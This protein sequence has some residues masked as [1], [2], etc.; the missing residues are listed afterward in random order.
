MK[1]KGV[2]TALF[3]VMCTAGAVAQQNQPVTVKSTLK[4]GVDVTRFKTYNWF[5]GQGSFD[6][7]LNK[8]IIAAID[9]ELATL[10]LTKTT[11][12]PDVL[13]RCSQRAPISRPGK[14]RPAAASGRSTR[15]ARW[16]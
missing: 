14:P 5:A 10:G 8:M 11:T 13:A 16:S 2:T 6:P 9:R 4:S 1:I 7:E 12:T 15:S 3:V